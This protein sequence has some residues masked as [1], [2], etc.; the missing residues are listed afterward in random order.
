MDCYRA[1][2]DFSVSAHAFCAAYGISPR[3]AVLV[4]PDGFIGCV[5]KDASAQPEQALAEVCTRLL[6]LH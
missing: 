2:T 1:G 3:G 4:R 6:F 5:N